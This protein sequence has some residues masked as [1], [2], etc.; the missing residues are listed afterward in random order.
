MAG[1]GRSLSRALFPSSFQNDCA[2]S[3]CSRSP[4]PSHKINK[5]GSH[6]RPKEKIR[7]RIPA[8]LAQEGGTVNRRFIAKNRVFAKNPVFTSPDTPDIYPLSSITTVSY[9]GI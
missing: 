4:N 5:T 8:I 1:N 6:V 9:N 7:S 2:S 3:R